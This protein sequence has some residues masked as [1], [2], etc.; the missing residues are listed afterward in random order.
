MKMWI[1]EKC[2][3]LSE[4]TGW[5]IPSWIRNRVSRDQFE[6][7]SRREQSL[8]TALRDVESADFPIPEGL[9][10]RLDEAIQT[11]PVP[12]PAPARVVFLQAWGLAAAAIAVLAATLFFMSPEGGLPVEDDRQPVALDDG[13]SAE[14]VEERKPL[15]DRGSLSGDL[16]LEPLAAEKVRL[17]SDMTH[18]LKF[19]ANSV[20]PDTYARQFN[21]NLETFQEQ[22]GK[23]I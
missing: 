5:K 7:I 14:P 2:V 8:T 9:R 20:L 21:D 23:S 15:L 13:A 3:T 12:E 4:V 10:Q 18:A 6:A 22:I 17:A 1:I 11:G 19:V 16:L